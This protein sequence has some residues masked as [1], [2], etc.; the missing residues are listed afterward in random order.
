MYSDII[1]GI[2]VI[3]F[4]AWSYMTSRNDADDSG[5]NR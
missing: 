5:T 2:A 4:A 3:V 1:S